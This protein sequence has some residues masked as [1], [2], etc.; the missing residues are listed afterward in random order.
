WPKL[1]LISA[2]HH[3]LANGNYF[4]KLNGK[5]CLLSC[6]ELNIGKNQ[7][8]ITDIVEFKVVSPQWYILKLKSP[9]AVCGRTANGISA[10]NNNRCAIKRLPA[11]L[12]YYSAAHG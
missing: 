2:D 1:R 6:A 3:L 7:I 4:L 9:E 10:G 8:I 11:F 12:I 5:H